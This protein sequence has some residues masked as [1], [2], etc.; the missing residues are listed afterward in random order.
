MATAAEALALAEQLGDPAVLCM[1]LWA[2][3]AAVQGDAEPEKRRELGQRLILIAEESHDD[4]AVANGLRVVA[5]SSLEC[6]DV[7]RFDASVSKLSEGRGQGQVVDV[8]R[9]CRSLAGD[10]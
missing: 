8:P 2:S 3:A 7:A 6:G 1:S 4:R 10:E 5:L 9:R